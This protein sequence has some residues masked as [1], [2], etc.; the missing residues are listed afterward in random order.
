M[1][2]KEVTLTFGG[3]VPAVSQTYQVADE[4]EDETVIQGGEEG[5]GGSGRPAN[6]PVTLPIS[7]R[8]GVPG[9]S[10]NPPLTPVSDQPADIGYTFV[11]LLVWYVCGFRRLTEMMDIMGNQF[12]ELQQQMLLIRSRQQQQ[13]NAV[14]MEDC[15]DE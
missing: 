10:A 1:N 7:E 4:P 11:C 13:S 2:T 3:S 15:K 8:S 5:A 14:V 12:L 9:T 6:P